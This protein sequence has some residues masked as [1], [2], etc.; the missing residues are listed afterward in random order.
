MLRNLL[1][2]FDT[3]VTGG[4]VNEDGAHLSKAVGI[5]IENDISFVF[6]EL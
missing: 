2:D 5:F 4:A 1:L 3:G 6:D